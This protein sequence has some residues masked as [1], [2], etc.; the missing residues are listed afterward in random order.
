MKIFVSIFLICLLFN[1]H[2]TEDILYNHKTS[3][4]L[5]F[6]FTTFRH[7]ARTSYGRLD[8]FG[9]PINP[10]ETLT[11]YGALQHYEIGLKY[12]YRY[13]NFVNMT[14]DKKQFYIRSSNSE[15]VIISTEKELEGFFNKTINRNNIHIANLRN[16]LW[17]LFLL[18]EEEIKEAEKYKNYC[19]KRNLDIDYKQIFSTEIFPLLKN[20]YGV[21][22]TPN[23]YG[24]C[25]YVYAA[26]F[27]Y[28]YGNDTNNKIG[29]C[30]RENATKIHDFC[31]NWYNTFRGWDEYFAYMF[32][33][34]FKHIFDFMDN[35]VNG[36]SPLKMVMIGGHET[37]VDKFMNFLDGMKLIPRTHYPHFACNI[38]IE[39]RKY[40]NEY[41]LEFYYND[42][43]KYNNTLEI[44]KNALK[45]SKYSNLY[46]YCGIPP[47]IT[48]T[49]IEEKQNE[50]IQNETIQNETFQNE[51]IQNKTNINKT[52]LNKTIQNET[53]QNKTI[54]EENINNKNNQN[55]T[56]QNQT[57]HNQSF[58]F[59]N[60]TVYNKT[61]QNEK[62]KNQTIL[63]E[64]I[65][66]QTSL[67]TTIQNETILNQTFQNQT[68]QN[69]KHQ[70]QTFHN[71]TIQKEIIKNV[72][73]QNETIQNITNSNKTIQND[74]IK[75]INNNTNTTL[76][77]ISKQ[78]EINLNETK[79]EDNKTKSIE[80]NISNETEFLNNNTSNGTLSVLIFEKIKKFFKQEKDSNIYIILGS[81]C[82]ILLMLIIMIF[83]C[84]KK[85]R[86]IF[87]RLAEE[88]SNHNSN[89]ISITDSKNK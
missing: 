64:N 26:Y 68:I 21:Q 43:L 54:H 55:Q 40:N 32:Y 83:C 47:W 52:M 88:K 69:E 63:I 49:D 56:I 41:Y 37:T 8:I 11:K 3:D 19:K 15:R 1:I 10:Q 86:K 80:F 23:L 24:F 7:G 38:V 66:N 59:Q 25:D 76:N 46:N 71:Q 84:I 5:Y 89:I 72:T 20:C 35:A 57:F 6:V 61:F 78:N 9:N 75:N 48:P 30:G 79:N 18:N 12:R 62:P 42:I 60:Q 4:N 53:I 67:N 82:F 36:N 81:I 73:I 77:N 31:Y 39:L 17:N 50:I 27:E 16:N 70:N 85:K 29:K 44:F 74:T 14:F 51:A 33:I 58:T 45:V 34:L 65:K 87:S 13:S 22:N 2:H 28:T